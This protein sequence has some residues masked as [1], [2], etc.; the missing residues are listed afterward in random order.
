M[1]QM[2]KH[3]TL[4]SAYVWKPPMGDWPDHWT[5]YGKGFDVSGANRRGWYQRVGSQW[6]LDGAL[7]DL[8]PMEVLY[9]EATMEPV[10]DPNIWSR[11]AFPV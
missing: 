7:I 6:K 3:E 11:S 4:A 10:E 2:P 5:F 1:P 9:H 8:P